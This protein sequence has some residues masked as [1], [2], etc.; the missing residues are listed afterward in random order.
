M[1]IRESNMIQI[2]RDT[3]FTLIFIFAV[4]FII[5]LGA[6][7]AH[8]PAGWDGALLIATVATTIGL[9]AILCWGL[10]IHIFLKSKRLHSVYWYIASGFLPGI[11]TIFI[12]H[13]F[14]NDTFFEKIQQAASLGAFGT[15]SA[16]IF[17]FFSREKNA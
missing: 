8:S 13:F 3:I 14:G 5:G 4:S 10:P 15:I 1:Q 12:F 7:I 16:I 9:L 17:W 6:E 2:F 11:V